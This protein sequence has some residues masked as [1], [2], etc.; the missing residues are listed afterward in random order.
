M[1]MSWLWV[2]LP[3]IAVCALISIATSLQTIARC[4]SSI[5]ND[6]PKL[7]RS[8]GDLPAKIEASSNEFGQAIEGYRRA[9]HPSHDEQ[10][11]DIGFGGR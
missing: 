3:V 1:D 5:M 8:I 6:L 11:R 7:S 10:M 2:L 9:V 4:A